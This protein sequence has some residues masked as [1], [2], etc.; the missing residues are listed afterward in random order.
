MATAGQL[1]DGSSCSLDDVRGWLDQATSLSPDS[2]ETWLELG[3]FLDAVA[4]EPQLAASAFE[5]A[6]EKSLAFLV[7]TLD[8]LGSTAP[9]QDDAMKQRL[10]EVRQYVVS[11]LNS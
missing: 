10:T 8:G 5:T 7:A 9:S 11:L 3:H 4:D 6:L 2:P 1:G